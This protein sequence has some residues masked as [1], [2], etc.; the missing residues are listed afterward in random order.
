MDELQLSKLPRNFYVYDMAKYHSLDC[1]R[2]SK[3]LLEIINS[4]NKESDV[5]SY[6]KKE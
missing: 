4:A 2:E 3:D 1:K 6:I 5:Q